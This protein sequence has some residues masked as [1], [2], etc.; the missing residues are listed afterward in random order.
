MGGRREVQTR[1][2]FRRRAS[3]LK[4]H[5]NSSFWLSCKYDWAER[6][7]MTVNAT[8]TIKNCLFQA[9]MWLWKQN[10]N[11]KTI[12]GCRERKYSIILSSQV[13]CYL[14]NTESELTKWLIVFSPW[15][16]L[17]GWLGL[18]VL[19]RNKP[20]TLEGVCHC[21]NTERLWNIWY[22]PLSLSPLSAPSDRRA[23]A[24]T[25]SVSLWV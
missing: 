5:T 21:T 16:D 22:R 2:N 3:P 9:E 12:K 17:R 4:G 6:T 20:I 25:C 13:N 10:M 18:Q 8:R 7:L 15:Y 14:E 1:P 11:T 23:R 24:A 19:N